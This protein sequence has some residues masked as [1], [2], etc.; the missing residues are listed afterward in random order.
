MGL[1]IPLSMPRDFRQLTQLDDTA[2][3]RLLESSDAVERIWAIW[4][5][6][7]RTS[8]EARG[9]AMRLEGEPEP[10]VRRALAVVIA[11][12]KRTDLLI[13]LSRHDPDANVRA[14]AAQ[15]LMRFAAAGHVPWS[16]VQERF[17]DVA[18]V[19]EAMLAEL[20]PP[21]TPE[22][23]AAVLACLYDGTP[24]VRLDAFEAAIRLKAA[25]Q[26]EDS[27]IRDWLDQASPQDQD[28]ALDRWLAIEHPSCLVRALADASPAVRERALRRIP[29]CSLADVLPLFKDE[30]ELF[31]ELGF[32]DQ[33]DIAPLAL[34]I[35]LA[36]L[37][38]VPR[39]HLDEAERRLA[40]LDR[41]PSELVASLGALRCRSVDSRQQLDELLAS[42]EALAAY[43]EDYEES[44]D[45]LVSERDI[46]SRLVTH[47]DRLLSAA[48]CSGC[49]NG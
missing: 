44:R 37:K 9:L 48:T 35:R 5:L 8:D 24:S 45:E 23:C 20:Q 26:V 15:L 1:E 3:Y 28:S 34:V 18:E 32:N 16:V 19:R 29:D 6:G 36:S 49:E 39:R 25:K 38:Y 40:T 41:S 42:P 17:A 2:L 7:L 30:A 21:V 12:Q 4:A 14:S 47:V 43:E 10:G 31:W 13:A 33:L 22:L 46:L 11:G 27:V